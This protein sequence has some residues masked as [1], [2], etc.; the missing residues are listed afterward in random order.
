MN[1]LT[2]TIAASVTVP[3]TVLAAPRDFDPMLTAIGAYRTGLEAYNRLSEGCDT[4]FD[5]EALARATYEPPLARLEWETPEIE[6]HDGLVA[7]LNLAMEEAQ[8]V[9]TGSDVIPALL[10]VA[11]M[12]LS[13]QPEKERP[14][15]MQ[16]L[17]ARYDAGVVAFNALRPAPTGTGENELAKEYYGDLY[18]EIVDRPPMPTSVDGA[19]AAL[20]FI[21]KSQAD[22]IDGTEAV[23]ISGAVLKFLEWTEIMRPKRESRLLQSVECG[24]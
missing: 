12:Y 24:R 14:D 19:I 13:F 5:Y 6:S 20:R 23:A 10:T 7:A 2:P 4:N 3:P 11:I 18:S 8:D 22:F 1:A 21:Q 9:L 16:A 15:P 17:I